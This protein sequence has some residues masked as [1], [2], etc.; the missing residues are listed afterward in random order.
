MRTK[1]ATAM[2]PAPW[3]YLTPISFR[4][5]SGV[6]VANQ[7]G[8]HGVA[9]RYPL[10]VPGVPLQIRSIAGSMGVRQGDFSCSPVWLYRT[11]RTPPPK[12]GPMCRPYERGRP[13]IEVMPS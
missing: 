12:A 8:V 4:Q 13:M 5:P 2:V 10:A 1:V 11:D 3:V 6:R 7:A 9:L